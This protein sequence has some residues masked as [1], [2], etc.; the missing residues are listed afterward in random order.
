[1]HAARITSLEGPSTVAVEEVPEPVRGDDEVL[2][3]VHT[4]GVSFP[5]VL[6][7]RGLYQMRPEL[8]FIPGAECAGVV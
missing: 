7:S 3:E 5:D 2:V 1:M 8:P 6:L 4:A